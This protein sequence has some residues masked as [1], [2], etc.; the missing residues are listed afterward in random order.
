MEPNYLF[1]EPTNF[2]IEGNGSDRASAIQCVL[3]YRYSRY[4]YL[5]H[6]HSPAM[7]PDLGPA[8][9]GEWG[10]RPEIPQDGH[11][12]MDMVLKQAGRYALQSHYCR[13]L[14]L[15]RIAEGPSIGHSRKIHG[16]AGTRVSPVV[17]VG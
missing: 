3:Q 13:N 6:C 9:T 7:I 5:C 16:C 14:C 8:W 2:E 11:F 17:P 15:L 12:G 4:L 10:Q 1:S